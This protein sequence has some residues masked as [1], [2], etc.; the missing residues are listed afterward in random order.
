MPCRFLLVPLACLL[1]LFPGLALAQGALTADHDRLEF[2]QLKEGVV[3]KQTVTL[4]NPGTAPVTIA[5]VASSCA[6]TTTKLGATTLAPGQAT[7]LEIVYNTY[8]FPGKFEKTVTLSWGEGAAS[9][10]VITLAGNV[11]PIPMGVLEAEPRKVE[12][13]DMQVGKPANLSFSMKNTGDAP[14]RIEKVTLQK[15]GAVLF[16]AAASAPLSLAPGE[17][18]AMPFT[19]TASAPGNYL[20]YLLVSS[21]GR[22]VTEK[23]YK[24]L[25]TGV[26]K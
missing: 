23:G 6:C 25:V 16:D 21:D 11:D 22:N 18:K 24:V 19:V 10:T 13:G 9:R 7:P 20:E 12:A 5:N 15:A 17:S 4:M 26:A 8:K 14:L 1:A 2:G 3:A